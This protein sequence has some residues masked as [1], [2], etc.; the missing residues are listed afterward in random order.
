MRRREAW[1]AIEDRFEA[2][3]FD[4]RSSRASAI[5]V[6]RDT[7]GNLTLDPG[8]GETRLVSARAYSTLRPVGRSP[9]ILRFEGGEEV[10]IPTDDRSREVFG[11]GVPK[12]TRVIEAIENRPL[13]VVSV[14]VVALGVAIASYI[15]GLPILAEKIAPRVPVAIKREIGSQGFAFLDKVM[16][17]SSNLGEDQQR[18]P[19]DIVGRLQAVVTLPLAPRVVTRRMGQ[20]GK[21]A[22]NAMAILPDTIVATDKLV[23]QLDDA[24]L[25]AVLAHEMGHLSF[26]HGTQSLVRGSAVSIATLVLFGGDPGVFQALAINLID[27]KNS[28]DHEKQ[29]DRFALDALARGGRD[30]M[31]LHRALKKISEGHDESGLGSYLSSHPMPEERLREVE[32]YSREAASSTE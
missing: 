24:E 1:E 6:I 19:R 26:D 22:A 29:A 28:R 30:P 18:R 12:V 20:D 9:I 7:R 11:L 15:Y 31:A 10:H 27:S 14:V 13:S 17:M 5:T 21:D 16:F 3:F 23:L 32:R 2:L 4:G 25:E 8:D